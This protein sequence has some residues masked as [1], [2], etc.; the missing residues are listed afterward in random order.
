MQAQWPPA[1]YVG[2]WSRVD[3]FKRE[4]LERALARGDVVKATVMRGTLHLIS[5][6][7]YPVFWTLLH[8]KGFWADEEAIERGIQVAHTLR[9]RAPLTFGEAIAHLREE[10]GLDQTAA[11]RT[12]FVARIRAHLLHHPETAR[13][14]ARPE[15]RFVAVDEPEL[16]DKVA[17]SAA[18]V[19]R[20][21]AAFG[22]AAKAD[23][24]RWGG[25][26]VGEFAPGLEA[27]EPLR[28]FRDEDGR[29]LVDLQRTRLPTADTPAPVR[30]LPKWDNVILGFDDRRRILPD[31]LKTAVIAKNGEVA[32]TVLVDGVV[33]ATWRADKTGK[34]TVTPFAPLPRRVRTEVDAEAERLQAWLR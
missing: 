15:A 22:P 14:N 3:G 10:H 17:A 25:L 9:E 1:P 19:R 5:R 12:W 26:K 34:V 29:E 32:Q 16:V 23:I 4:S 18:V 33:A 30:F 20:Y 8:E 11:Q 13:W 6:R 27:L 24:A 31:E 21:L 28:R 7:D 2:L